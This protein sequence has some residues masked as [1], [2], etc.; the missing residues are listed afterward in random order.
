MGL[1]LPRSVLW[2]AICEFCAR[3]LR[4]GSRGKLDLHDSL[5]II[6]GVLADSDEGQI[7][8][9]VRY[10]GTRPGQGQHV[11]RGENMR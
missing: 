9:R 2:Q 10:G 4:S 5:A 1:N 11:L 6:E 3:W 7:T 8:V